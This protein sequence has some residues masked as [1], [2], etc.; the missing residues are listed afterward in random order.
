MKALILALLA[1]TTLN[2]T[3]DRYSESL[4][5]SVWAG[6]GLH[7]IMSD[8]GTPDNYDDDW[9]IDYETNREVT[10]LVWDK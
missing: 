3:G 10:V 1:V 4:T 7:L 5:Y 8:N 6:P 2:P 9:V